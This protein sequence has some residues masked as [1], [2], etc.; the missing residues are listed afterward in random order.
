MDLTG[1]PVSIVDS[2]LPIT[3]TIEVTDAVAG[4]CQISFPDTTPMDI[5]KSYRMRIQVGTSGQPATFTS[6]A[7]E[8]MV[9]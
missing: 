4:A 1:I 3:P 9:L 8:V 7:I 2:T 5:A 6:P